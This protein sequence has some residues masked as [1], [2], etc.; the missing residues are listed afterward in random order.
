MIAPVCRSTAATRSTWATSIDFNS[1]VRYT[2]RPSS[3]LVVPGSSLSVPALNRWGA[4]H[5]LLAQ[6][7]PWE[8][9]RDV[10]SR[11]PN[12]LERLESDNLQYLAYLTRRQIL[13]TAA[14][15]SVVGM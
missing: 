4:L 2:S 14:R 7:G 15:R 6:A 5:Y 1:G 11:C 3:F 8:H 10:L 9:R 13:Q 12:V